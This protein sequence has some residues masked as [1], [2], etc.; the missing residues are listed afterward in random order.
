MRLK[1]DALYNVAHIL[2]IKSLINIIG[3]ININIFSCILF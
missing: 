2:D 1:R 3:I